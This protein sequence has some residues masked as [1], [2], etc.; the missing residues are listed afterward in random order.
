MAMRKR[1]PQRTCICCGAKTDKSDL[2]RIV[3]TPDGSVVVDSTGKKNGRGAYVC[4]LCRNAN[5][6][7]RRDRLEHSLRIKIDE[8]HWKALVEAL[9]S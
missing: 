1:A 7:M 6:G 2:L 3:G 9:T 4:A 5:G 8:D